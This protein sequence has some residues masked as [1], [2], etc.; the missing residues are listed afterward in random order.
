M[1]HNNTSTNIA[2]Y[3]LNQPRVDSV[4]FFFSFFSA[5]FG[6]CNH[7]FFSISKLDTLVGGDR[8]EGTVMPKYFLW[9]IIN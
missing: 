9:S 3:R 2:T 5:V 8:F 4:D 6:R 7:M 1:T